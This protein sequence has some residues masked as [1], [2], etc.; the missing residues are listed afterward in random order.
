MNL[1]ILVEDSKPDAEL[2]IRVIADLDMNIEVLWFK[3]GVECLDSLKK[4]EF[5][6]KV[7]SHNRKVL[8]LLDLNMPKING[9]E[10]L[11][12]LLAD[13]DYKRIP[14]IVYTTSNSAQDIEKAY[15]KG[16]CSYIIK[17]FDLEDVITKITTLV[18]YWFGV[19]TFRNIELKKGQLK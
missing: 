4:E 15:E 7:F 11:D 17:P 5:M 13:E 1:I 19:V 18:E 8:M 3:N 16:A 9:L 10:L 12:T 2:V 6:E 14:K